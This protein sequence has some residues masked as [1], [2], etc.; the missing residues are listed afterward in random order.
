MQNCAD[1]KTR[2][3]AG[4]TIAKLARE[5]GIAHNTAKRAAIVAGAVFTDADALKMARKM[6]NGNGPKRRVSYYTTSEGYKRV[7]IERDDPMFEMASVHG[8]GHYSTRTVLEHRLVLARKLGRPLLKHE[9]VH[10]KDGDRGNN[11]PDN[12]EL[13]VGRHGKG[14]TEVHCAT[15]TCFKACT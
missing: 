1:I 5:F 3:E 2:Y 14:A 15:C 11:H 7:L 13:R 8:A 10:H 12:L 6:S 9:T 4:E